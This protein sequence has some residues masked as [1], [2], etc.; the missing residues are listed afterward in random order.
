M[1]KLWWD[2]AERHQVLRLARPLGQS[3]CRETRRGLH[4]ARPA[5]SHF[6]AGMGPR[7][8]TDVAPDVRSRQLHIEAE[9]EIPKMTPAPRAS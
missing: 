8:R 7:A 6:H 1:I 5:N 2:E 4:G 3:L 9:V